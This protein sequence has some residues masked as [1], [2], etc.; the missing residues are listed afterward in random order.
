M[1]NP[2][3]LTDKAALMINN[4]RLRREVPNELFLRIGVQRGGCA[5]ISHQ[6]GFDE[7]KEFDIEFNE[8]NVNIVLDDRHLEYLNGLTIDYVD[9][10]K[11]KENYPLEGLTFINP[12]A[13]RTCGCGNSFNV[14]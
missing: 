4:A 7:K 10:P 11:E 13:V 1:T 2:V 14:I 6:V 8:N 5:G 12:N 3:K 9:I